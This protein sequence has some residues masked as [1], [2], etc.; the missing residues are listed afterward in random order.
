LSV[1]RALL[2]VYREV[3]VKLRTGGLWRRRFHHVAAQQEID[4]AVWSFRGFPELVSSL[5]SGAATVEH[6]IVEVQRALSSLRQE[7]PARFWPSPDETRPELEEFAP[8]GEFGSVF[9][10][11]PQRDLASGSAIPCDAWGLGMAASA[12]SNGATYA[13]VANAPSHAWR[14][15]ARGEV[16]LHEWLH[17]V[18][19]GFARQGHRMPERDADGAELHGYVRSPT[20]GWTDY[21]RDL[22]T[23]NVLENGT[24]T[25]IPLMAW[26]GSFTRGAAMA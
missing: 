22:M 3:D 8:A 25:G 15:E 4:D 1:T 24:R 19:G 23:G 9:V 12:W 2:L 16:W 26:S 11:W 18:C 20:A 5:T 21:Y 14:G 6:R 13:A 17:G 7:T 10:F